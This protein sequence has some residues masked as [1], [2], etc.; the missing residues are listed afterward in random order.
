MMETCVAHDHICLI[1]ETRE[2][3]LAAVVPFLISGLERGEKCFYIVDENTPEILTAALKADGVDTDAAFASGALTIVDPGK[4][5]LKDGDFVPG[6]MIAYLKEAIDAAEAEGFTAF[7]VTGE[8]TWALRPPKQVDPLIE[9]ECCLNDFFPHQNIV[10]ICQYNRR[11]FRPETLLHVL[12]THPFVVHGDL[13]CENP[14]YVP[15]EAFDPKKYDPA[16]EVQRLLDSITE[17]AQLKRELAAEAQQAHL[18]SVETARWRQLYEAVLANTP[19][20]GY[21]FDLNHRVTFANGALLAIWGR[22]WEEAIG[23]PCLDLGYEPWHAAMREREIDQVVA[24]RKPVHGEA[25]FTGANGRRIYDYILFPVVGPTGE[26]EAVGGSARDITERKQV[27]QALRESEH[28]FRTM[29]ETTPE[30]VK[31]VAADG[32]LLQMNPPGLE[33]L[34]A[35]SEEEVVG[36]CVYDVIA[37]EYR[38]EYRRFN[39]RVCGGWKGSLRFDIVGL[40][41]ARRRLET[42]ATPLRMPDGQVVH[43]A[44]TRDITDRNR[45]ENLLDE[46]KT[47]LELIAS[48]ASLEECLT[49]LT[50]SIKRLWPKASAAVFI[51]DAAREKI[52]RALSFELPV[53]LGEGIL[54]AAICERAVGTCAKAIFEG[55]PITCADVVNDDTWSKPWRDLCVAH[56]VRAGYSTPV[57][58][59]A[60]KAIASF[61]MCF[62]E[63]H[64]PDEWE[65]SLGQFGAHIAGIAL[66]RD[67]AIQTARESERR[68]EAELADMRQLQSA[69]SK[70]AHEEDLDVLY[71]SVLDAAVAVMRSDFGSMQMLDPERGELRLLASRGFSPEAERLWQWVG[72]DDGSSCGAALTTGKRVIVQ[73]SEQC[74]WMAGPSL[75]MY[76][77]VGIRAV[78]T[79]PLISRGGKLLGMISTHW[80]APH[81]PSERDLRGMDILARQAADL[82]DRKLAAERQKQSEAALRKSEKFAAAGRMAATI[83]HE[84]N[85]PLEAIVNLSYLLAREDLPPVARELLRALD[86]ELDRV[87]HI[88]KQTLEFYRNGKT[89]GP[90]DIAQPIKAAV[91]LFSRKA[92]AKGIDVSVEYRT[93]AKIF[94]FSGELRQVFAN[95]IDNALEAGSTAIRI[96]VSPSFDPAHGN[97][98][99]V[100]V[101]VADNGLGI[102]AAS[103]SKLFQPF[104][105]TKEEKG[106]GLGLWVSRGI[107]Q[108]HEGWIRMRTSTGRPHRGTTFCIFLPTL[109]EEDG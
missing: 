42:H 78:Q 96:R 14:H 69:S 79:T 71:E 30:C 53:A 24:T 102:P 18:L 31:L 25:P 62:A 61:F 44:L 83:A 80:R 21:M 94:G 93:S 16:A 19:D 5:Y 86:T 104:F 1:Y 48:G 40:Q 108:K 13:I 45:A 92:E 2:E 87:S 37:P 63:P 109:P 100:S 33:I 68:L 9:Y 8:T 70:I 59:P 49:A 7:R 41:G 22:T 47:L 39:E 99:G 81:E 74:E 58:D 10:A 105:T 28:R 12:H 56:G 101:A 91:A 11:R 43:L 107:I 64:E 90:M 82:L 15:P 29:V 73:D 20:L 3:Q 77:R 95:L 97:R 76:R 17:N 65:R 35:A 54:G 46:Q 60:G 6:Q 84:I 32:T 106:T 88:A 57:F 55:K 52:E 75:D 4:A 26:V 72:P 50:A 36:K 38:E 23:H 89:S 103:V 98:A 67:R 51:A 85:N 34:G 66:E 27:E